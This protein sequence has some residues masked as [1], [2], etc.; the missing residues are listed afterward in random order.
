MI[1]SK[2]EIQYES[3]QD[4]IQKDRKLQQSEHCK[5]VKTQVGLQSSKFNIQGSSSIFNIQISKSQSHQSLE[6]SEN[7]ETL[8]DRKTWKARTSIKAAV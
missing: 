4:E 5:F 1:K 7:L 6:S 8:K 2:I 3:P